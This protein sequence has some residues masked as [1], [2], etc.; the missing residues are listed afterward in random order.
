MTRSRAL[1]DAR[2]TAGSMLTRSTLALAAILLIGSCRGPNAA[3]SRPSIAAEAQR[4]PAGVM[5]AEGADWLERPERSAEERPDLVVAAMH[6]R[7]G[8][9]VAE[10]GAGS[11]YMARRVGKQ[12]GP[13]GVVYAN[14]IQQEMI[15]KLRAGAARERLTNVIPVLGSES[16]PRL[17]D[18]AAD[19]ILLV[20][21]YHEFQQPA[22]MLEKIHRAL[23]PSGRVMLVEYRGDGESAAH[24]R[25]EHRMTREQV[26]KEWLPAG[27][28]L[29][30]VS[31]VLPSQRMF[32]FARAK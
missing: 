16:D 18:G 25:A 2:S 20:D 10:I 6:L 7:D 22:P 4:R 21:V 23:K 8:D 9:V 28:R 13:H 31:E 30:S 5:S 24:I 27:F 1:F 19:W 3:S 15:D 26:L 32:V 12:V 11:G 29:E 17:P 14:D